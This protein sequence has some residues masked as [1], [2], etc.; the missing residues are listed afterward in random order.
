[1]IVLCLSGCGGGQLPTYPVNGKVV[2]EDGTSPQFGT[3][4]FLNDAHQLNAR[5]EIA[6]D[7]TFSVSTFEDGDGAVEGTH[8]I[9]IIQ[10]TMSP[11]T[12]QFNHLIKHD[13]GEVV[14]SK[15]HDFRTSGLTWQISTGDNEVM[16][17]VK[18]KAGP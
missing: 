11:H 5:G 4:E 7:G 3:V 6:N 13:H 2:F 10:L 15:Y 1:M 8:R 14:D 12:A 18:K 9:A 17:T 16:L